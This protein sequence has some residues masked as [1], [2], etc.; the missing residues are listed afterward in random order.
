MGLV[1]G[2]LYIGDSLDSFEQSGCLS[3]R[4]DQVCSNAGS[5]ALAFGSIGESIQIGHGDGHVEA[6]RFVDWLIPDHVEG[7]GEIMRRELA[8]FVRAS[9]GAVGI[10]LLTELPL[11][12]CFSINDWLFDADVENEVPSP[13]WED[14]ETRETQRIWWQ[15]Q[16]VVL[17]LRVYDFSRNGT[18]AR[19]CAGNLAVP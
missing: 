12:I 2:D 4:S 14:R 6:W 13:G 10:A 3:H 19:I 15:I 5:D 11:L 9:S 16:V 17:V 8:F 18:G 1:G 7:I